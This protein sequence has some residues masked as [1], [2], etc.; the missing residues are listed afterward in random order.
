MVQVAIIIPVY[1]EEEIIRKNIGALAHFC[2]GLKGKYRIII[3]DNGSTDATSDY[4]KQL[5]R[6]FSSVSYLRVNKKGKGRAIKQGL[7][8][9][10]SPWYMLMDCDL[11][12]PITYLRK[13]E[14]LIASKQ[15][16]LIVG[17]R[18]DKESK[19]HAGMLRRIISKSYIFLAQTA[20]GMSIPD[21]Q[22]GFK[23]WNQKVKKEI[24]PLCKDEEWFLDTE[25]LY[26]S[27]KKGL[28]VLYTPIEY[29]IN[30]GSSVHIF[31]DSARFFSNLFKLRQR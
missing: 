1:N 22:G 24:F 5:S 18:H 28:R 20:L 9:V 4:G 11:P 31:S 15:Y 2:S 25:L 29:T 7:K 3:V 23:A 30:S 10:D 8:K 12:T 14:K 26:F 13:I 19:L 21:L 17:N 6:E 27:H 16:D